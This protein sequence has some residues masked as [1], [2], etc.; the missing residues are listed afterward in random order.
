MAPRTRIALS[1]VCGD[2]DHGVKQRSEAWQKCAA[3]FDAACA[4]AAADLC[5]EPL[6]DMFAFFDRA[7]DCAVRLAV[8]GAGF[9][10]YARGL[11]SADVQ[12]RCAALPG[13][14]NVAFVA[15]AQLKS[16]DD[17]IALLDDG[18]DDGAWSQAARR[19][20]ADSA[21]P[22]R[23]RVIVCNDV[24]TADEGTLADALE[25]F[26]DAD[27]GLCLVL[28]VPSDWLLP[29]SLRGGM[30][31]RCALARFALPPAN[32]FMNVIMEALVLDGCVVID[33]AVL[34]RLVERLRTTHN[35]L[36]LISEA[37]GIL[38]LHF[39]GCGSFACTEAKD[40]VRVADSL[41]NLDAAQK[42]RRGRGEAEARSAPCVVFENGVAHDSTEGREDDIF[43]LQRCLFMR[44]A[45]RFVVDAATA[46]LGNREDRWVR[47]AR[48]FNKARPDSEPLE[49]KVSLAVR[50]ASPSK[51]AQLSAT[52]R[53]AAEKHLAPYLQKHVRGALNF[54]EKKRRLDVSPHLAI[55]ARNLDV[56]FADLADAAENLARGSLHV[57]GAS[58]TEVEASVADR[59]VQLFQALTETARE[60]YAS[61]KNRLAKLFIFDDL[62]AFDCLFSDDQ[63][64]RPGELLAL[65]HKGDHRGLAFQAATDYNLPDSERWYASFQDRLDDQ[66]QGRGKKRM[67]NT[68]FTQAFYHAFRDLIFK[69]TVKDEGRRTKRGR[70][71]IC[72]T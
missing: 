64:L 48:C 6:D 37:H 62:D 15:A 10:E 14:T 13:E 54:I 11:V 66:L 26:A 20:S 61:P 58:K 63:W 55:H 52:W 23:R 36:R 24:E 9:G 31:T 67:Q 7:G 49:A 28:I 4:N 72:A 45:C 44:A 29:T 53:Q 1:R 47:I 33:G 46:A 38:Y 25:C 43:D 60:L 71:S 19:A 8:V 21:A 32:A 18:D 30:A 2:T 68:E 51:L 12:R 42:K 17:C 16:P 27:A 69:G 56:C 35:V 50:A 41:R 70:Y 34:E 65:S 39:Q 5:R 40:L 22:R 3:D 57:E 59:C